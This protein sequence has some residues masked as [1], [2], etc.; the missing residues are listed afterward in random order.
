MRRVITVE[1]TL[2][3][4]QRARG[5]HLCPKHVSTAVVKL[6]EEGWVS[7]MADVYNTVQIK[8]TSQLSTDLSDIPVNGV[9]DPRVRSHLLT[10]ECQRRTRSLL[11]T[12]KMSRMWKRHTCSLL[13]WITRCVQ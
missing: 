9:W 2:M 8:S 10:L 5:A 11:S 7:S 6:K 12:D 1:Q 4:H 13:V 3:E